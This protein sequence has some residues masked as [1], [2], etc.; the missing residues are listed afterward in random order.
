MTKKQQLAAPGTPERAKQ[1][2]LLALWE[3]ISLHDEIVS[4]LGI[5]WKTLGKLHDAQ[6]VF[7]RVIIE[8]VRTLYSRADWARDL[9][10]GYLRRILRPLLEPLI[11]AKKE[12]AGGVST[13]GH[14]LDYLYGTIAHQADALREVRSHIQ[15]LETPQRHVIATRL[16]L[17]HKAN[18]ACRTY[19]RQLRGLLIEGR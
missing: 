17:L 9:A 2:T 5:I 15:A 3:V 1:E 10:T 12:S 18:S 8:D 16:D 13:L 11:E 14:A 7:D 19:E 4:S 6:D